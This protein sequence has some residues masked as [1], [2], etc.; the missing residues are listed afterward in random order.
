MQTTR[1][2]IERIVNGENFQ[3]VYSD[4]P[5]ILK[6]GYKL[7]GENDGFCGHCL[8]DADIILFVTDVIRKAGKN[9]NTWRTYSQFK[10]L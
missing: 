3:I 1:H 10:R 7:Q 4:T 5:G 2:H 6:P 9:R 8:I